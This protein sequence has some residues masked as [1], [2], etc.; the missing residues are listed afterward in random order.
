MDTSLQVLTVQVILQK[1]G[2]QIHSV[3]KEITVL[4]A[5][6]KMC[7]LKVGALLVTENN[8]PVGIISERD[9]MTR[10]VLNR[11]DV[12]TTRVDEVMTANPVTI[13]P[14]DKLSEA[15]SLMTQKRFRHL[16]V[17]DKDGNLTGMVSI[18]DLVRTITSAQ[19][20]MIGML[21]DYI[22]GKHMV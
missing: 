18:G 9:L 2:Q 10:V 3:S 13:T 17:V 11:K 19:E 5:V 15:M 16:P 8:K 7:G 6:E 21:E 12:G 22:T 20:E 14:D 4:E 1:K